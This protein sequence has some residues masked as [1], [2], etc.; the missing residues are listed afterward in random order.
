MDMAII[1]STV[2][3]LKTAFDIVQGMSK[4]KTMSE[5]QGK[6]IELQQVILAAQS[7]AMTA[8]A[9]Q[10]AAAD[11][12]RKLKEELSRTKHWETEKTRYAL[13]ETDRHGLVVALRKSQAVVGEPAHFLC[14]HCFDNGKKAILNNMR[15]PD[16]FTVWLCPSCKTQIPTGYRGGVPAQF[17]EDP[18]QQP[19]SDPSAVAAVGV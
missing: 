10:Y 5:V 4:L 1:Q 2:T 19:A 13:F 3:G 11:E 14:A 17:A 16:H 12:L 9:Q 15:S 8:N 7:D 6:V 18:K